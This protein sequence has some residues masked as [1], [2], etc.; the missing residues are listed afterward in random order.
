MRC[1]AK[2][3]NEARA[4]GFQ[5]V[6]GVDEVGRGALFG[7]VFAAAVILS[8]D[9]PIRG[10]RDSKM[11]DAE[12]REV[13]AARIRERAIAWSVAAIDA[14]EID[15]INILQ[16]SRLAMRRAI[17]HLNPAADYLLVDA[18]TVELP[19]SQRALIHGDALS[20]CIAAASIVAKVERDACMRKWDLVFPH[21]GL[22]NHKGYST[23]EHWKALETHGPTPMHRFSFWPVRE[24]SPHALWT[25]Y[26]RQGDLFEGDTE[27]PAAAGI[28]DTEELQDVACAP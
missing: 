24:H 22:K 15:R 17:E 1:Q 18:V 12:R 16:A 3:E 2:Y 14:F 4:Q 10:L 21:Y 23:D 9:R 20:Q 6:A 13:L 25:G 11:L 7:P 19:L 28:A 27:D 5:R 26:P 8:P